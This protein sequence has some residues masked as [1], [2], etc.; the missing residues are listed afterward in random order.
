MKK[1]A[2]SLLA[3]LAVTGAVFSFIRTLGPVASV[4]S[5]H[6][7]LPHGTSSLA[8]VLFAIAVIVVVS[9]LTGRVFHRVFRQP[10]VM[11]EIAAGVLLGPSVLG[12]LAPTVQHALFS[13]DVTTAL[14]TVA[15]L[16]V[17]LFMFLIGLEL[18][19]RLF[20]GQERA[21]WVVS[22]ASIMVP[23]LLGSALALTLH[24]RYAPAGT[25]FTEFAL[26]LGVS[27]SV[28]AFPVLARILTERQLTQTTPGLVALGSAAIN[29][30]AAW[31][32]LAL[33]SG[34]ATSQVSQAWTTLVS[35]LGFVV[36][37]FVVVRP[38]ARWLA[39][40]EET[41][42]THVSPS[43]L[44]L[45]FAVMLLA[46]VATESI[47]IHALFGAFLFGVVMPSHGRLAEQLRIRTE[48][49]VTVLFLPVF[50]AFTGL[51]TSLGLV[52]TADDW[53]ML[54]AIIG[55]AS[56]GKLGGSALAARAAG[57]SWRDSGTIGILMNTRG[58]MELIVLNV[59]LDL[60]VLSPKLFAMLV[61]MALVTTFLTSP[62]LDLVK[63]NATPAP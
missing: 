58:L 17:V 7:A 26:F 38:L 6:V 1:G 16:G 41:R 35:T 23:F 49:V 61:L 4:A 11:G 9:R 20:R 3:T 5:A 13:A 63:Q 30:A 47:G 44:S 40:R 39:A 10:A 21:T 36:V 53:V 45:V 22:Q 34:V 29:D 24:G 12:A 62:L 8:S 42:T 46:A 37:M 14:N 2:L 15:K 33:A 50:F 48:D 43:V 31:C 56:V 28:T 27:F 18:D 54:G 60:G 32:L 55:V 25:T 19:P 51:R 57:L 59:G 52:D